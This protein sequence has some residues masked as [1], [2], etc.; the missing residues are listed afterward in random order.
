MLR[1]VKICLATFIAVAV[2]TACTNREVARVDPRPA[3]QDGP[4][5][6]VN[7]NRKIDI[8]FVI[9]N[10]DSM[11][12]E[13]DELTANFPL[14]ID[15]LQRIDG[16]LPDL[17]LG[18]AST[19][20]GASSQVGNCDNE[21]GGDK[22][23]LQAVA[24]G[25]MG[26]PTPNDGR[27]F[28]EDIA[29]PA[30]PNN[31][32]KNYT[33]TLSEAFQCIAPLG[34]TGCGFEMPLESMRRALEPANTFNAGFIRDDAIL[35]IVIISDE[36][37]CSTQNFAM[38]GDRTADLTS[39]LGPLDSFRCFE[40]GVECEPD[41]DINVRRAAGPRRNCTPRKQSQFMYDVQQR[42]VDFLKND[43]GKNPADVI[44]A[45][46][47]GDPDPIGVTIDASKSPP[48]AVLEPS[49]II[50]SQDPMN[51]KTAASPS[52]RLK[53]FLDQFPARN[54]FTSICQDD[55][56]GSLVLIANLLAEVIGNPCMKGDI[57]TD[58]NTNGVQEDCVVT[59]VTTDPN[60]PT[61]ENEV[62]L[63]KCTQ[64]PPAAN[65]KPCWRLVP[66]AMQCTGQN[67]P[68]QLALEVVR[69]ND[70]QGRVFVEAACVVK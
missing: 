65:E 5:V 14:F 18:V 52:V 53:F 63:P 13:Q 43:L 68:S 70:P 28:L 37:D 24:R 38:F 6:P 4:R 66:D 27:P 35:A 47:I 51:P 9:D 10:S 54:T 11:A 8:L 44:V 49:C 12:E 33:G 15:V 29:D 34:L 46:I 7:I 2:S 42:Y 67:F 25:P 30:D 45:G 64:D 48:R 23:Q 16:G 19:D 17:H 36:D 21:G 39:T 61:K 3:K 1:L 57:D 22:G 59:E 60:D 26:C 40:F 62:I 55:L 56:S 32:I 20:L 58:P 31:R 69:D 50:P 41:D